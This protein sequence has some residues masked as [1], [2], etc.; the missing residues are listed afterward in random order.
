VRV[1]LPD[2]EGH[3]LDDKRENITSSLARLATLAK[4]AATS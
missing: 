1:A 4:A 2:S 3:R